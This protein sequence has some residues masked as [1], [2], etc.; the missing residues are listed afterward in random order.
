[1]AKTKAAETT[2][3][4]HYEEWECKIVNGKHEKI[5]RKRPR[6]LISE[7][8]AAILNEGV[9][10]GDNNFALMYFLPEWNHF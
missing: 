1:M 10:K 6:V 7:E 4:P 3:R 8:Q 2:T 9:L 5:K